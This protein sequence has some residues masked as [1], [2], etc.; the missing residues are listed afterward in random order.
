MANGDGFWKDMPWW[1]KAI[2]IV[3]VPSLISIGV[4]WSDRTQL[5]DSLNAQTKLLE[6]ATDAANKHYLEDKSLNENIYTATKETNRILLAE[7][8]NNAKDANARDLCVGRKYV[9][10]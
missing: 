2:A 7:C 5:V 1:V 6:E 9:P 4:V 8:I 10:F 3:G